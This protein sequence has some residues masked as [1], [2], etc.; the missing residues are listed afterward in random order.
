M[1]SGTSSFGTHGRLNRTLPQ[2][3]RSEIF[4]GRVA[5]LTPGSRTP[6]T[7]C[8]D[9]AGIMAAVMAKPY[10]MNVDLE[11]IDAG[12]VDIRDFPPPRR[13]VVAEHGREVIVALARRSTST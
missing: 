6:M 1:E 9:A 4:S 13:R 5:E 3:F 12:R 8:S 7:T 2:E 11:A 10:V